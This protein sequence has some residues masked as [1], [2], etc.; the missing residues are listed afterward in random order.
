MTTKCID[1]LCPSSYTRKLE[2][3]QHLLFS[4]GVLSIPRVRKLSISFK[5]PVYPHV[6]KFGLLSI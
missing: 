5:Q 2:A 4:E 3:A 6:L 1:I